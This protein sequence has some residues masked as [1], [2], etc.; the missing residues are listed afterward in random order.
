MGENAQVLRR[1][2]MR[3]NFNGSGIVNASNT[4]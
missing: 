4:S 3:A 2:E 1:A